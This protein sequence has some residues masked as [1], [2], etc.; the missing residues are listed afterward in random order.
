[1]ALGLSSMYIPLGTATVIALVYRGITFWVPM[2]L[3]MLA[4]RWLTRADK[5]EPAT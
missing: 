5:I 3:G 4:F 2:L 1:M